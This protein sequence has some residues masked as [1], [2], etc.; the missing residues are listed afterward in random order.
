MTHSAESAKQS[1]P[2]RKPWVEMK[3]GRSPERA[4]QT[5]CV[6]LSGLN[7]K[8]IHNPGFQLLRSFHPGLYCFALSALGIAP[9]KCINS[10]P[11]LERPGYIQ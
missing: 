9:F 8:P 2:G 10:N 3:T 5:L 1:S 4:K 11:G 6:A 7:G